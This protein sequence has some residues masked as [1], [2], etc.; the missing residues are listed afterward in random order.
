MK[1]G[2]KDQGYS[3][4]TTLKSFLYSKPGSLLSRTNNLKT[5]LKTRDKTTKTSNS[6]SKTPVK[7]M[8]E[9]DQEEQLQL[10]LPPKLDII[11]E[12]KDIE[13]KTNENGFEELVKAINTNICEINND[14]SQIENKYSKMNGGL[15]ESYNNNYSSYKSKINE[16]KHFKET[17]KKLLLS[18]GQ[19]SNEHKRATEQN[20]YLISENDL[21][22][23][24]LDHLKA[25]SADSDKFAKKLEKEKE[26]LEQRIHACKQSISEMEYEHEEVKGKVRAKTDDLNLLKEKCNFEKKEKEKFKAT[27]KDEVDNN[28]II[29]MDNQKLKLENTNLKMIADEL[30]EHLEALK[31]TSREALDYLTVTN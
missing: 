21:Y 27:F 9:S 10:D 13:P 5:T 14:I 16:F 18:E 17:N 4:H 15:S 25:Y 29:E 7:K 8:E 22:R 3:R 24:K 12:P 30:R 28:E 6:I 1:N 26:D 31:L 23:Q 2:A 11:P 20:C 19:I